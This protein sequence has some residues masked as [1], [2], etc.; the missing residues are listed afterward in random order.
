MGH[1]AYATHHAGNCN[2]WGFEALGIGKTLELAVDT[3]GLPGTPAELDR[4]RL[5]LF[6]DR[7]I[8]KGFRKGN[9]KSAPAAWVECVRNCRC[10]VVVIE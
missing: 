5:L 4:R 7:A 8:A 6:F 1:G 10:V 2:R 9:Q 3:R